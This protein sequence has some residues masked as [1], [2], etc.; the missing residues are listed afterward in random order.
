M[1]TKHLTDLFVEKV[2]PT[3]GRRVEYF[4]ATFKGLALRVTETGH[5]SWVLFYRAHGKQ[6]RYTWKPSPLMKPAEA[7]KAAGELLQK[8]QDGIDPMVER[9]SMRDDPRPEIETFDMLLADYLALHANKKMKAST[10][11]ETKRS[12]ERDVVDRG[13]WK[14]LPLAS[15]TKRRVMDLVDGIAAAG[16]EVHANRIHSR[17]R[18]LFNWAVSKDR[19]TASPMLGLAAPTE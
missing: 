6:F 9:R 11:A 10:Y 12:L 16:A 1:P 2:K 14:K 7:R 4:D 3:K 8:V 15:I 13:K 18:A 5:K 19:M 17:L